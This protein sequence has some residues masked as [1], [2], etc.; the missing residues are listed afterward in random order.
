MS[1]DTETIEEIIDAKPVSEKPLLPGIHPQPE[2]IP[3]PAQ[4]KYHKIKKS[5][6]FEGIKPEPL[7]KFDLENKQEFGRRKFF[8]RAVELASTIPLIGLLAKNFVESK[9]YYGLDL[10]NAM[11]AKSQV[12]YDFS[13]AHVNVTEYIDNLWTAYDEE[14]EEA[15][16]ETEVYYTYDKDGNATPHYRTHTYYVWVEPSNV[17]SHE[18]VAAWQTAQHDLADKCNYVKST[19]IVDGSKLQDVEIDKKEASKLAQGAISTLMYGGEIALLLGYE[20][21][22]DLDSK[23]EKVNTRKVPSG[24]KKEAVQQKT[25][26]RSFL[27]VGAA[28]LGGGAAFAVGGFNSNLAEGGKDRLEAKIQDLSESTNVTNEKAFERYFGFT[29]QQLMTRIESIVN[30]SDGALNT[31]VSN[32]RVRKSFEN[33]SKAGHAYLDYL[34]RLFSAGVPDD[35]GK[36]LNYAYVTKQIE[37]TVASERNV[38][39]LGLLLEGLVVGGVLAA[40]L[41]PGEKLNRKKAEGDILKENPKWEASSGNYDNSDWY[42]EE[43]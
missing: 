9:S 26:R 30:T 21:L 1:T 3:T 19:K 38:P 41:I 36:A 2:I 5:E 32:D 43:E 28:L 6:G 27:K 31:G 8:A 20:E 12:V 18:K 15:R 29:Y 16:T 42:D 7:P 23:W 39:G 25:T 24:M 33:L 4:T 40:V 17:P 34:G 13:N 10:S 14:Y 35:V 11:L 22:L 37:Q